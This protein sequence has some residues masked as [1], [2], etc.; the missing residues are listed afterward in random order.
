M[1]KGKP[2]LHKALVRGSCAPVAGGFAGEEAD[3]QSG[4]AYKLTAIHVPA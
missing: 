1:G 2:A 3:A 4:P